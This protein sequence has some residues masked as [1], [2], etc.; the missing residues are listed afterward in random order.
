[1]TQ[2][3]DYAHE[4]SV[5]RSAQLLATVFAIAISA[6]SGA[7]AI[8]EACDQ[9]G[10]TDGQCESGAI[11]GKDTSAATICL[12]VC[13]AQVDCGADRDCNGVEGSNLKGC[14]LKVASAQTDAG[15]TDAAK[16]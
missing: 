6:C 12:K 16:K 10:K 1:M 8:G 14:R 3:R 9:S 11:C 13:S 2:G 5:F 4:M 15:Q 7:A